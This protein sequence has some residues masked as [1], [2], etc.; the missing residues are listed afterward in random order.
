[1]FEDA[2]IRVDMNGLMP[3]AMA[4]EIK[5]PDGEVNIVKFEYARLEKYRF[6]CFSLSHEVI[7]LPESLF[8][9]E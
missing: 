4:M 8:P 9:W 5:L 2:R 3:L 6:K 1:M 7:R